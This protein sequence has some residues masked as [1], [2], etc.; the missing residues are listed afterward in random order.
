M[1]VGFEY[2]VQEEL[3]LLANI[4]TEGSP[5]DLK[6][7]VAELDNTSLCKIQDNLFRLK[8]LIEAKYPEALLAPGV[9]VWRYLYSVIQKELYA[10]KSGPTRR[11]N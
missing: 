6:A 9:P 5:A 1:K 2:S 8:R 11:D 3:N 4:V 10:R 7:A